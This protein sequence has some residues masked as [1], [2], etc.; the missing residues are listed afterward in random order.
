MT[1]ARRPSA[2]PAATTVDA[3]PDLNAL[4]IFI[5]VAENGGFTAAA[6]R[7]GLA[8]GRIS[9]VVRQLEQTQ[10]AGAVVG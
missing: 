9:T 1:T 10:G 5:A 2:S 7:V 8:K 6:E 3:A 4:A